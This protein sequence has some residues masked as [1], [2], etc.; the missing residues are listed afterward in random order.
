MTKSDVVAN[1]KQTGLRTEARYAGNRDVRQAFFSGDFWQPASADYGAATL[2]EDIN[3]G[4]KSSAEMQRRFTDEANNEAD[5]A[6]STL[7]RV[8]RPHR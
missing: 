5:K 7:S 3:V 2:C 1:A 4:E 6:T 8:S